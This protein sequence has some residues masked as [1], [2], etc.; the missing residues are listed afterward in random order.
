MVRVFKLSNFIRQL[1]TVRA[2]ELLKPGAVILLNNIPHKVIK[3]TFGKRG[4]GGG[5]VKA[6]IKNIITLNTYEKTFGSDELIDEASLEKI[7]VQ[8]SWVDNDELVFIDV[9]SFEEIRINQEFVH[10]YGL[11]NPGDEYRIIK[12]DGKYIGVGFPNIVTCI[13]E[14]ITHELRG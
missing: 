3:I 10:N 11:L 12:C 2:R 13:V 8:F 5:F 7:K 9:K 6:K 1:C 4:K 14:S